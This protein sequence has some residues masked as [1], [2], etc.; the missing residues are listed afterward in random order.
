MDSRN[1]N[2]DKA[3]R[4]ENKGW[5]ETNDQVSAHYV[6]GRGGAARSGS[7]TI[8]PLRIQFSRPERQFVVSDGVTTISLEKLIELKIAFGMTAPD[9]L[10]DLGDVQG[11]N[12]GK[13]LDASFANR[14]DTFAQYAFLQ[15]QK[16]V[17]QVRD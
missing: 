3:A 5:Q 17:Q 11:L 7:L 6:H 15:L 9:R 12:K 16:A 4:V 1:P 14:L 10:K 2:R 13:S 8:D